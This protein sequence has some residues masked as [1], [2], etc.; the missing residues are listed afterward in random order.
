ME[1]T[2]TDVLG[3]MKLYYKGSF[4]NLPLKFSVNKSMCQHGKT[5]KE[6]Q[7]EMGGLYCM[8]IQKDLT[9]ICPYSSHIEA[10]YDGLFVCNCNIKKGETK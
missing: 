2:H 4:P 3:T 7:E 9:Y 6:K 5:L 1:V 10:G 8:V